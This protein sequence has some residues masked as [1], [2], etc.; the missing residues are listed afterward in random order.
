MKVLNTRKPRVI[1]ERVT[2]PEFQMVCCPTI[3][4]ADIRRRRFNIIDRASDCAMRILDTE[5][6]KKRREAE[7]D[8]EREQREF[9]EWLDSATDT[10]PPDAHSLDGLWKPLTS[11]MPPERAKRLLDSLRQAADTGKQ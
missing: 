8:D 6:A 4:I 1:G 3:C 11:T 10:A 7:A 9:Q 5:K 2:V